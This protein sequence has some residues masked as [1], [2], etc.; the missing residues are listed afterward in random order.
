MPSAAIP[1]PM[2]LNAA[3]SGVASIVT[4]ERSLFSNFFEGLQKKGVDRPKSLP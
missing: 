3:C 1:R 2:G 4:H